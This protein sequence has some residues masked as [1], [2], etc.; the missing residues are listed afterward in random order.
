MSL[1]VVIPNTH[2]KQLM[3]VEGLQLMQLTELLCESESY[4]NLT[5][6]TIYSEPQVTTDATCPFKDPLEDGQV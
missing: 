6:S 4:D 2:P 5:K 3:R 1:Y